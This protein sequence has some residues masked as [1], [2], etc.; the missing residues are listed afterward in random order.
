MGL[1][2]WLIKSYINR[3]IKKLRKENNPM[4]KWL[5]GKKTYI[6]MLVVI[7]LGAIGALNEQGYVDWTVPEWVFSILGSLGIAARAVA[8]PK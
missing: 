5:E 6:T 7:A 4:L 1:K 3:L 2:E 8:R